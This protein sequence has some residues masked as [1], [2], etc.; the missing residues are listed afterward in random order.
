MLL[1]DGR[2]IVGGVGGEGSGGGVE[3]GAFLGDLV[4]EGGDLVVEMGLI[5]RRVMI[6]GRSGFYGK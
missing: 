4:G 5:E 6:R 1:D 3:G 2:S